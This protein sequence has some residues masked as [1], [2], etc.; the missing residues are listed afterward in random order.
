MSDAP[1]TPETP[2]EPEQPFEPQ[3]TR[4]QFAEQVLGIVKTRFPLVK[5]ARSQESFSLQLNG[6]TAPLEN[7][8]RRVMLE[9]QTAQHA[10]ERWAVELIRAGEGTPDADATFDEL[11]QRVLPM[12]IPQALEEADSPGAEGGL[13]VTQ[14][15]VPAIQIGY[16][17]DND[18]T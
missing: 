11:K 6:H 2:E 1:D 10:I 14:P 13:L 18:R 8:Y 12:V 5:I 4:E 15:L 9:P 3:P 16:A 17:L 7:L